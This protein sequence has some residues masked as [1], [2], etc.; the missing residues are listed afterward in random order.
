M[1]VQNPVFK[2]VCIV[3]LFWYIALFL[4]SGMYGVSQWRIIYVLPQSLLV[5]LIG[6][7]VAFGFTVISAQSGL[8][9]TGKSLRSGSSMRQARFT[10]GRGPYEP[11]QRIGVDQEAL[12]AQ[13]A[14]WAP[15]KRSSPAYADAIR[16]VMRVMAAKPRLPASPYPGG[17]GGRTLIVHS[18]AVATQMLIEAP[19]WVYEG[20]RDKRGNI[21]VPLRDGKPHRFVGAD[22]PLLVL[23]G[24]AHDIGKMDCYEP[25][26]DQNPTSPKGPLLR[27]TEVRRM[28]DTE[29]A[30]LL[31]RIPE[32]ML[33][34]LEDRTALLTAIGYYHHPFA[35]PLANWLTD[36]T[37]S[38][39]ECLAKADI[40]VGVAE[41]HTLLDDD[42]RMTEDED[43][44]EQGGTS[45]PISEGKLSA[46]TDA[47]VTQDQI[48]EAEE[49]SRNAEVDQLHAGMQNTD[50]KRRSA[51]V[52]AAGVPYELGLFMDAIRRPGAINGKAKGSRF[53][54]KHGK[55]VYVLDSAMR[56][57][58]K[59]VAG[60][61]DPLWAG[62]A[63]AEANGNASP[64]T[65]DLLTQLD[66]IGALVTEHDGLTYSPARAMFRMAS[67]SGGRGTP[68]FIV[69]VEAIPGLASIV[70]AD[71]VTITG[72]F[73]GAS[74]ARNKAEQQAAVTE[75]TSAQE[76]RLASSEE[77]ASEDEYAGDDHG[78]P[79]QSTFQSTEGGTV[80]DD[81][82]LPAGL[83]ETATAL[84]VESDAIRTPQHQDL[85]AEDS[86]AIDVSV[87]LAELVEKELAPN[88][89]LAIRV[90]E[91][92]RYALVPVDSDAGEVVEQ[93]IRDLKSTHHDKRFKPID[94]VQLAQG[95][96]KVPAYCFKLG[97]SQ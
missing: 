4:V 64:F 73:W 7:A 68:V 65:R 48:N 39:T 12:L 9:I 77:S 6:V 29:G 85:V 97:T 15:I 94:I 10:L 30:R 61:R 28:H 76:T 66:A 95:D 57:I 40:A 26:P 14:W 5:A 78:D 38:L 79:M 74:Q 60:G 96:A 18:L 31:R 69:R 37:R 58:I 71:P 25:E 36:R 80:Y 24:L 47:A 56:N 49:E 87:F 16:A 59:N 83:L 32:I 8:R 33:L 86:D 52:I 1:I 35:L 81:A 17:H 43:D 45:K 2:A 20:Q 51:P 11:R 82:D 21:R 3:T 27:V 84:S 67:K 34:P 13:Q 50:G 75:I 72:P 92:I 42:E 23:T 63:F 70:D 19:K 41:G 62:E 89:E 44:T 55:H 91:S 46:M 22:G 90:R 93:V 53:A 54:W 88:Y